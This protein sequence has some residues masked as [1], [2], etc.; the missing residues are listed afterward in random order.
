[1]E[2][3][4]EP[5]SRVSQFLLGQLDIEVGYLQGLEQGQQ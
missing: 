2:L 4:I 1:M 3:L 5:G